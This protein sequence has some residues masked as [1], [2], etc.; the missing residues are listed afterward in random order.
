V[1]CPACQTIGDIDLR[2][3]GRHPGATIASLIPSLSCRMCCPNPPFAK[4]IGLRKGDR[5]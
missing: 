1:L 4:L 3:L 5:R 2:K